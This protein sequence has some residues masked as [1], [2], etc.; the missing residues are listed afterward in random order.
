MVQLLK[1]RFDSGLQADNY[2]V[3]LRHR[4]QMPT[5]SMQELGQA[6]REL[7]VKAYPELQEG[8]RER[9]AKNHFHDAV[10]VLDLDDAIKAA[11]ET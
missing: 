10:I 2:L 4:R 8:A 5:E 7:T 9:L 6:V 11:L 3:E 1:R